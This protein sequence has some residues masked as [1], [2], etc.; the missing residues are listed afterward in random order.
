MANSDQTGAERLQELQ[1]LNGVLQKR[2][3]DYYILLNIAKIY[4]LKVRLADYVI[5]KHSEEQ[6]RIIEKYTDS[7]YKMTGYTAKE[8][9]EL[10]H[11]DLHQYFAGAYAGELAR[12]KA[13]V[14]KN[15][16]EHKNSFTVNMKMPT[17]HGFIYAGGTAFFCGLHGGVKTTFFYRG[18]PGHDPGDHGA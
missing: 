3:D 11:Y 13:E 9:E 1:R 10:F 14:A 5:V 4:I 12:L 6:S 16:R 17:K 18:L 15:L 2:L 7:M 8:Y